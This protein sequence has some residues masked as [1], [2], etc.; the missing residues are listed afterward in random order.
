M[1]ILLIQFSCRNTNDVHLA[2][3]SFPNTR[4]N[5][6]FTADDFCPFPP[7]VSVTE[8]LPITNSQPLDHMNYF[9][10]EYLMDYADNK[11]DTSDFYRRYM[12][13]FVVSKHENL[14]T[15]CG[16]NYTRNVM[17][18][19]FNSLDTKDLMCLMLGFTP[20]VES[21]SLFTDTESRQSLLTMLSQ[22]DPCFENTF[23]SEKLDY[24]DTTGCMFFKLVDAYRT[25]ST[26]KYPDCNSFSF[27]D[28]YTFIVNGSAVENVANI[29]GDFRVDGAVRLASDNSR[30]YGFDSFVNAAGI[31]E[32]ELVGR[33]FAPLAEI[34]GVTIYYNN[35]VTIEFIINTSTEL[36]LHS[37]N[38]LTQDHA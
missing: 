3:C 37:N 11:I 18:F 20:I 35:Q 7:S 15:H 16:A 29:S 24:I 8:P 2:S 4:S 13:G 30:A 19:G 36:L 14:I 21:N 10:D 17:S 5:A 23:N 34:L 1:L 22:R 26:V 25:N 6:Y 9:V 33:Q 38:V 12:A 31:S 32:D 27:T 28:A